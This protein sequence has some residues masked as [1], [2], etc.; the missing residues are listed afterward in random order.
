MTQQSAALLQTYREELFSYIVRRVGCVDTAHDILQDIFLRLARLTSDRPIKNP[1]AFLYRITVNLVTDRLRAEARRERTFAS[2]EQMHWIPGNDPT[3]EALCEEA[4]QLQGLENALANLPPRCREIFI[5]NR[6]EG[7]SH[8]RI[9]KEMGISKSWVEKNV[10]R[11]IVH[12]KQAL[13]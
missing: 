12:L 4:Q 11:A 5:L 13:I 3:P 7:W 1:R 9:A 8:E 10:A 2:P 6:F